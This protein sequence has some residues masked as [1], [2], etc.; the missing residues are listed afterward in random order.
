MKEK[1]TFLGGRFGLG[2]TVGEGGEARG[3][4]FLEVRLE[5]AE[6]GLR[7]RAEI[8]AQLRGRRAKQAAIYFGFLG[9]D[10][11]GITETPGVFQP[12]PFFFF[13]IFFFLFFYLF[14]F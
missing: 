4:V 14:L 10:W 12:H 7:S 9:Q 3:F 2:V 1:S 13:F 11:L 6:T 5:V 8:K